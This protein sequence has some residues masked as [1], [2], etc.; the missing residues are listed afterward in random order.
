[1][2]ISFIIPIRI[3][4]N[5]RLRNCISIVTYLLNTVPTS[6]IYI[7]EVDSESIFE[8]IAYPE[9]K[10]YADIDNIIHT[11]EYKDANSLFHRTK[12]INDLFDQTTSKV[13][14]HYDVDVIF[15]KETYVETYKLINDD[16]Y[17]FI[18]PY[19]CGV[20]QNAVKYNQEIYSKFIQSNFDLTI[21]KSNSFRLPSTVGFSQV[22]NRQSYINFGMMNE[23]FMSWGCEDCELYYRMMCLQYKVGRV[24]NDVYHLEHSRTFNS[25]YNN[26]K[27]VENDKLWQWFRKQDKDTIINYYQNQEYLKRRLSK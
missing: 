14:W 25:H 19:G 10:K 7:K 18:Y 4:S 27:F 3:E 6:K 2:D 9:I 22:F 23:N 21:L 13:V 11:F 1:M 16:G 17:D 12:Y 5:D 24:W 20:Y 15:P 26:P 8:K